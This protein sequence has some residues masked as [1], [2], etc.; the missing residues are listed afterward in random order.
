M[1]FPYTYIGWGM[2]ITGLGLLMILCP[3]A[4][5]GLFVTYLIC[6]GVL[7]IIQGSYEE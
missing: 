4:A 1:K 6:F 7:F 2:L 5:F 3:K